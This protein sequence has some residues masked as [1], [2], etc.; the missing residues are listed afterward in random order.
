[1]APSTPPPPSKLR[2]AAL[3]MAST[4]SVVMSATQMS[5]RAAPTTALTSGETAGMAADMTANLSRPLSLRL[6]PQIDRAFHPDI[7]KVLVE[8]PARRALTADPEL[9]DKSVIG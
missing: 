1:M 5:S 2:F 6:G 3:T 8:E 7:V 9:L 4:A